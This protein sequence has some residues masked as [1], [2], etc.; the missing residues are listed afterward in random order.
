MSGAAM[1]LKT[2]IV[3]PACG[4]SDPTGSIGSESAPSSP[5]GL[6]GEPFDVGAVL[7]EIV[8]EPDR[9]SARIAYHAVADLVP[10]QPGQIDNFGRVRLGLVPEPAEIDIYELILLHAAVE[11]AAIACEKAER[12]RAGGAQLFL[13][14]PARRCNGALTRPR[15]SAAGVRP[16]SS[17]VIFLRVALLQQDARTIIDD[18]DGERAMQQ[19]S[20]V[21]N[22]LGG[23]PGGTVEFIDQYELFLGHVWRLAFQ[24]G[25]E[26]S[27]CPEPFRRL[28][29]IHD[30][31][32][33]SVGARIT[34]LMLSSGLPADT[35]HDGFSRCRMSCPRTRSTI[36]ST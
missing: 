9:E 1:V 3:A 15:M 4:P 24:C 21:D 6:S 22:R 19:P 17:G 36:S 16:Q 14:P 32:R 27:F 10:A 7:A 25:G 29:L 12:E 11:I 31:A 2:I 8:L 30:E 20:A 26:T 28:C 33:M 35:L 18:E 34:E 5:C 13:E 23:R